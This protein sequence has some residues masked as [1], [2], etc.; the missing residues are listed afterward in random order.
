M[1][2]GK[3]GELASR[4]AP[5]LAAGASSQ[6][7]ADFRADALANEIISIEAEFLQLLYKVEE[8]VKKAIG[9]AET[10]SRPVILADT[11]DNPG[12]G[13]TADTT[14]VLEELIRRARRRPWSEYCVTLKPRTR[15]IALA[16]GARSISLW[17]ENMVRLVGFFCHP[18]RE[19]PDRFHRFDN[20]GTQ[21]GIGKDGAPD[22]WRSERRR[23]QQTH[24]SLRSRIVQ[25]RGRRTHRSKNPGPQ[26]RGSFPRRFRA[27]IRRSFSGTLTWRACC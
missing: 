11:Q 14:G 23:Q 18:A 20:S 10:A 4:P 3:G 13:G 19:W 22:N 25:A 5:S 12:C 1:G 6:E 15:L 9:I 7:L 8:G 24:A 2:G 27:N 21:D 16:R 26:E 17:V